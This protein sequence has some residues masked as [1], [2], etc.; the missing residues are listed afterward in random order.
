M[1]I[2]NIVVVLRKDGFFHWNGQFVKAFYPGKG[3]AVMVF[4]EASPIDK[5]FETYVWVPSVEE[6]E[7][8]L[9]SFDKSDELTCQLRGGKGWDHGPRPY[10]LSQKLAEFM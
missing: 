3:Y 4:L 1:R 2:R 9:N 6:V 8:I 10:R 5:D 7:E